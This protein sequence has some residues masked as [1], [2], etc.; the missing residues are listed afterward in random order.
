MS[1]KVVKKEASKTLSNHGISVQIRTIFFFWYQVINRP[2]NVSISDHSET[3]TTWIQDE[4]D[5]LCKM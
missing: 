4:V 2:E 5:R 3:S 1:G